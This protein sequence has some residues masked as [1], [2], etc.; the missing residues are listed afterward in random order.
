MP[1]PLRWKRPIQHKK[2][3]SSKLI[4]GKSLGGIIGKSPTKI[5]AKKK[6]KI[7]AGAAKRGALRNS[8]GQIISHYKTASEFEQIHQSAWLLS[9]IGNWSCCACCTTVSQFTIAGGI[10]LL[11]CMFAI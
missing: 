9:F 2:L 7:I 4:Q 1:V 11:I 6:N 8:S 10:K 5:I 3:N